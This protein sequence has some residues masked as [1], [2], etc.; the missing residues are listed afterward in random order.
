MKSFRSL[1]SAVLFSL[2]LGV[3]AQAA[4]PVAHELTFKT[5]L[6]GGTRITYDHVVDGVP[7]T[8]VL[9]L[10][11]GETKTLTFPS[12]TQ[13]IAVKRFLWLPN[14]AL[15]APVVTLPPNPVSVRDVDFT[16]APYWQLNVLD[17]SGSMELDIAEF[18]AA[19]GL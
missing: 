10:R 8:F 7:R 5:L 18:P 12:D 16:I 14:P 11:E 2:A 6:P 4:V 19:S 9:Y 15:S 17:G 3:S 13:R 1:L